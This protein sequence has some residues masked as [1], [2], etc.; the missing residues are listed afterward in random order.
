VR[1]NRIRDFVAV[2]ESGSIRAAA[3]KLGV[4]QPAMTK[5]VRKL[6]EEL[7]VQ[8]MQ[9]TTR[10]VVPTRAGKAY[11]ARARVIQAEVR[12]ADEE[13][14]EIAGSPGGRVAFGVSLAM[15]ILVLPEALAAFRLQHPASHIRV[16]EGPPHAL[17]PLVREETL[18]F[19]VGPQLRGTL[20]TGIR[21][22]PLFRT[23]L[24]VAGRRGHPL[25]DAR[26]LRELA[27]GSWLVFVPTESGGLIQ[28][29]F[30]AANVPLRGPTVHCESFGGLLGLL[31]KT[32]TLTMVPQPVLSDPVAGER[33]QGIVVKEALP[34]FTI[35]LYSR[36]D[37]P[38]TRAAG[39]MARAVTA[40]A[41]RLTRPA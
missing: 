3:R 15:T 6:E 12:K 18:D 41:R 30:A 38:F 10:G 24:V 28:Q 9:R 27:D 16:V 26:S 34:T 36:A 17:V 22:R 2:I 4:S 5:S 33:L 32:D 8:L 19:V 7:H 31:A 21:F 23:R 20:D 14:A 35:G 39:A 1:L 11:L 25:R 37:T 29:A 40:A 13:L